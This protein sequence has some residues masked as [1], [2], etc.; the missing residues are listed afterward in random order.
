MARMLVHAGVDRYALADRVSLLPAT[1]AERLEGRYARLWARVQRLLLE[2]SRIEEGLV[3]KGFREEVEDR[4]V[5]RFPWKVPEATASEVVEEG[6][7]E[8][9]P[10]RELARLAALAEVHQG[11]PSH[12]ALAIVVEE[13]LRDDG[14]FGQEAALALTPWRVW[15]HVR[16]SRVPT[17]RIARLARDVF[18]RFPSR[19]AL[20]A[21]A[22]VR[23]TDRAPEGDLLLALREGLSHPSEAVR[24]ECAHCLQDEDGLLM[25]V[26][27]SDTARGSEAR[28]VLAAMG[29]ARLLARLESY[30]DTAFALDVLKRLPTQVTPGAL[31]A[32]F[33]V[34]SRAEGA[35]AEALYSW[36]RARPFADWPPEQRSLW[37]DWARSWLGRL[38]SKEALRF[39]SWAAAS[40][41]A[42]VP[43]ARAF[44]SAVVEALSREPA[45]R[46]AERFQ[47]AAFSRFLS[48]AD[49][50]DARPLHAWAREEGCAEPLLEAL[51]SLPSR[52]GRSDA[53]AREQGARLWMAIW[54]GADFRRL[55]VPLAK[56][57]R[58]WSGSSQEEAFLG[59]V[60]QRFRQQPEER[61]AL[62]T[63][64]APWR[65]ALWERQRAEEPDPVVCFQT[66][67]PVED[68][69][70]FAERVDALV[71]DAPPEDLARRLDPVWTAVE[72]RVDA[73]PRATS[74]AVSYA[75]AAL[76]GA[77]RQ[78][79]DALAPEAEWFLSWSPKFMDRVRGAPDPVHEERYSRDFLADIEVD[80][81]LMRAHLDQLRAQEEADREAELRRQVAES[82]RRDLERQAQQRQAEAERE[83]EA[84][85]RVAESRRRDLERQAQQRLVDALPPRD[86]EWQAHQWQGDA[87]ALPREAGPPRDAPGLL[88]PQGPA[89]PLDQEVCFP[90]ARLRTLVDYAR[91]VKAVSVNNADALAVFEAHGLT[92]AAW[93]SEATAWGA[94]LSRRM[95]LALRFSELFQG[96]WG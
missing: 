57:V 50:D 17:D 53:K 82:R 62:L 65:G 48:L 1:L 27:G 45:S 89:Q 8:E 76:S 79:H 63:A 24:F 3:L 90:E 41:L 25:V 2:V 20:A 85:R 64:F 71:R 29:S 21:V 75:A 73:W 56:A 69:A 86:L 78:G 28:R 43:E 95:D 46:R 44:M 80:A 22:W 52:W 39:L 77:L 19:R 94:L 61:E 38:S 40:D 55:V 47:D 60:W 10:E 14:L 5:Q 81:R 74:L 87:E 36:A 49:E 84:L 92:V 88:R 66:W 7:H 4:W 12:A 51:L 18:E 11:Q 83:A 93:S 33:A 6:L 91:L 16:M 68:P 96:A 31:R 9:V 30:G 26:E 34:S 15:R 42:P 58:A 70:L 32:L 59:A 67:W 23:A 72:A 35:L 54:Q 37:A 13:C